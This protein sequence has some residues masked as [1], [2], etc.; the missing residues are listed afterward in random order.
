M[1][2][3]EE[4]AKAEEG[5]E[6]NSVLEAQQIAKK[7]LGYNSSDAGGWLTLKAVV[8]SSPKPSKA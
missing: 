4:T 8:S 3:K 6:K 2:P 7:I 5:Q 1:A